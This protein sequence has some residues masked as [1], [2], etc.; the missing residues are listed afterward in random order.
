[1]SMSRVFSL[2][3]ALV[4]SSTV[5][6][7]Q[8]T[9]KPKTAPA[10]DAK[11]ASARVI[12]VLQKN[13]TI[14][15]Y[16]WTES[17]VVSVDGK[18]KN[19]I[20]NA[21]S[22]NENNRVARTPMNAKAAEKVA[23]GAPGTSNEI[24]SYVTEA[25]AAMREY[26]RPDPAK[27][28]ACEDAGRVTLTP[29]EENRAKLD[30]SDYMKKGDHLVLEIDRSLNQ[31]LTS[32]ASTYVTNPNDRAVIRTEMSQLPDGSSYPSKITFNTPG[33]L[34]SA[35]VTNSDFKKKTS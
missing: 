3:G 4:L 27:L 8:G 5:A 14:R 12:A 23:G 17:M 7:A 33:R 29:G 32:S 1:M 15:S 25:V 2:I 26:V 28:Q 31:I 19:K 18:E 16:G 20:L 35:V 13:T 21:C 6:L 30:Y 10:A 9:A 22:Y 11:A 34:M 24:D